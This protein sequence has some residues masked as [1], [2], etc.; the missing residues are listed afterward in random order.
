MGSATSG[1]ASPTSARPPRRCSRTPGRN[2]PRTFRRDG[3][4]LYYERMSPGN[5]DIARVSLV[6]EPEVEDPAR[7]RR[8]RAGQPR[9]ARR[10][11]HLLHVQRVRTL[12]RQRA[13]DRDAPSL[14]DLERPRA[15]A[16][17][18]RATAAASSIRAPENGSRSTSARIPSSR[19]ASRS[20]RT[21]TGREGAWSSTPIARGIA[22]L[23]SYGDTDDQS[24]SRP[25]ATVVLNWFDEIEQ[26]VAGGAHR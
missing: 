3:H 15:T 23:V 21:W 24:E 5:S 16:R 8:G 26:R 4:W 17:S 25:H 13:G 2:F 6:G 7:R 1:G 12:G 19:P 14:E 22:L 9:L 20:P 11:V 10:E 18:G